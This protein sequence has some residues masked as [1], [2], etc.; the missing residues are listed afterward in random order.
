[1]P[2]SSVSQDEARKKVNVK[3][4]LE[5]FIRGASEE[6]LEKK[7]SLDHSQVTHVVGVLKERGEITQQSASKREENL[8]IRFGSAPVAPSPAVEAKV[9]VD[10]DTGLV[11]HCPSCGAS[12]QRG[13]STCQYCEAHLDFSLKGKTVHCPHCFAATPAD[14]SFC[15]RCAQPIEKAEEE[16]AILENQPCPRCGVAMRQVKIGDFS[17][18]KCSQCG[19]FF[20]P[21]ETFDLMQVRSERVIFPISGAAHGEAQAEPVVRYLRCP[22]CRQIMN[23]TNFAKISGVI[24]DICHGHGIWFDPGEMEKIIDFIARGGLQK[25]KAA[26]IDR[27]K[28]EESLMRLKNI[29]AGSDAASRLTIF[30]DSRDS[31]E[32]PGVL[33][34]VKW[35]FG[36][37]KD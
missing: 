33:D 23:R 11:L 6:E 1:M 31:K 13:A 5:D 9:S 19:G 3:S 4:F 24:I 25:A 22:V 26:D 29:G 8:K 28:D 20:V 18:V 34:V 21:E 10:L 30:E 27:L 15:I 16:G 37:S 2:R 32:G 7:Y 17:V 36:G 14:S 12:V 35:V